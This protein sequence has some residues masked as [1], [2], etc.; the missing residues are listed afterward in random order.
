MSPFHPAEVPAEVPAKRL[1]LVE[2]KKIL[3]VVAPSSGGALQVGSGE[4]P[5]DWEASGCAAG[6]GRP[7][8]FDKTDEPC[9]VKAPRCDCHVIGGNTLTTAGLG[10]ASQALRFGQPRGFCRQLPQLQQQAF[11]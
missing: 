4:R 1:W 7:H 9:S 10:T 3:F 6:T 5:R 11:A 8:T 2:V